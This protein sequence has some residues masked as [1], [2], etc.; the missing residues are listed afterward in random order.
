M[1][2]DSPIIQKTITIVLVV[3]LLFTSGFVLGALT[4]KIKELAPVVEQVT[5]STTV[6]TTAPTTTEIPTTMAPT[7]TEPT[8]T[9]PT[10]TEPT[11]TESTTEATTEAVTEEESGDEPCFLVKIILAILDIK[12]KIIDFVISLLSSL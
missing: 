4:A 12:K 11:T 10:T 8:T 7:T 9:E 5:E 3:A 1:G 2:K 6:T